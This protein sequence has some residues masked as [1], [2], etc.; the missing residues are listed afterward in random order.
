VLGDRKE[1]DSAGEEAEE[2]EEGDDDGVKPRRIKRLKS[3]LSGWFGA[4]KKDL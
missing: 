1:G 4:P 2:G 3:R